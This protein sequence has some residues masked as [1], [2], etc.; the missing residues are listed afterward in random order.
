[1]PRIKD[2]DEMFFPL[3]FSTLLRLKKGC[4]RPSSTGYWMYWCKNYKNS[5][6]DGNK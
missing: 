3:T 6:R 2:G 4:R 5:F 1:L